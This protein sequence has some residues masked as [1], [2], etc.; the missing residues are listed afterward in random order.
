MADD[1]TKRGPQDSSRVNVYDEYE[2]TY[3]TDIL[4]C[5]IEELKKAV[6]EVGTS[7]DAVRAYL[8]K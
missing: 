7:A 3:W 8:N 5:S 4:G 2:V 6:K 1:E